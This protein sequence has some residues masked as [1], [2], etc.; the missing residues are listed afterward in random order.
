M[1]NIELQE[2][3]YQEQKL[4]TESLDKCGRTDFWY[5]DFETAITRAVEK[6]KDI[7]LNKTIKWLNENGLSDY[8]DKYKKINYD[9]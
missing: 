8:V 9:N 3:I 4:L 2:Y 6:E 5:S 7:M 1:S